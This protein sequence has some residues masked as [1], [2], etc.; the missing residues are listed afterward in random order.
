MVMRLL[1]MALSKW[2]EEAA[3]LKHQQF[4]LSGAA[5]R[6]LHLQL[7]KAFEKRQHEAHRTISA[8]YV[9]SNTATPAIDVIRE[10]A[11]FEV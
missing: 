1:A 6:L 3:L 4:P 7:S 5:Q 9:G 11:I 10:V 2:K 8:C